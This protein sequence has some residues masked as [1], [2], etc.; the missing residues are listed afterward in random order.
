MKN[1][2]KENKRILHEER[3][4]L[5]NKVVLSTAIALI[6][7]MV[8]VFLYNWFVSIYAR[9]TKVLIDVLM[10]LGIAGV[11]VFLVLF[12]V[13]KDRKYLFVTPYFA[14]GTLFMR[15]ILAGTVTT[16]LVKLLAKIPFLKI[17]GYAGATTAQRFNLIYI[18]IAIYLVASYI[19]YGIKI[20][21]L[22]K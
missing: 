13:K 11:A 9:Q 20:K 7:V 22:G 14:V 17:S 15:E 10:W 12:F 16:F 4:R 3:E 21:K 18:C 1:Q 8:M 6:G 2:N 19:Y 5:D